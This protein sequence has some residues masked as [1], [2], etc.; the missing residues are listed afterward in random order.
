MQSSN[1][2]AVVKSVDAAFEEGSG[3]IFK[4][5]IYGRQVKGSF[6]KKLVQIALDNRMSKELDSKP[7]DITLDTRLGKLKLGAPGSRETGS[8]VVRTEFEESDDMWGY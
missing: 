3:H 6:G 4:R 8:A 5:T 2:S 1:R 7:A